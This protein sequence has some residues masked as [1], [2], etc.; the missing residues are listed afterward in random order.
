MQPA[1]VPKGWSCL[2]GSNPKYDAHCGGDK[3]GREPAA[4]LRGFAA[5]CRLD[6]WV[7]CHLTSYTAK[8]VQR[9]KELLGALH[10][11]SAGLGL[12]GAAA[13]SLRAPSALPLQR[14]GPACNACS[15]AARRLVAHSCVAAQPD[16]AMPVH[17]RRPAS[18]HGLCACNQHAARTAPAPVARR[19]AVRG[20]DAGARRR[21]QAEHHP[22]RHRARHLVVSVPVASHG[23]AQARTLQNKAEG[24]GAGAQ[25]VWS[26]CRAASPAA[27]HLEGA[28]AAAAGAARLLLQTRP[29]RGWAHLSRSCTCRPTLL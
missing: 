16:D 7:F 13:S 19:R 17:L 29:A 21:R 8:M 28:A 22:H 5:A 1:A 4:L 14:Q 23:H 18:E 27:G 11:H 3:L 20:P 12:Q 9:F 26:H 25:G 15:A 10:A 2:Q 24:A 6:A